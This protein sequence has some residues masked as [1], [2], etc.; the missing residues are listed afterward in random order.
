MKK[1]TRFARLQLGEPIS[2]KTALNAMRQFQNGSPLGK[3][4]RYCSPLLHL[5]EAMEVKKSSKGNRTNSR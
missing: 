2:P 5:R 1:S 4:S 3:K